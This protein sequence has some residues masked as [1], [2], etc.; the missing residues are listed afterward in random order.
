MNI[1][2]TIR[3]FLGLVPSTEKAIAGFT[4]AA[5]HLDF[6]AEYAAAVIAAHAEKIASLKARIDSIAKARLDAFA[7]RDRAKTIAARVNAIVS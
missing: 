5:A 7:R 2:A 1:I 6:V 3:T 4:K